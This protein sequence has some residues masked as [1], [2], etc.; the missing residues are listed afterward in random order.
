MDLVG[1]YAR[2]NPQRLPLVAARGLMRLTCGGLWYR[3]ELCLA[4]LGAPRMSARKSLAGPVRCG[5]CVRRD[6]LV[7]AVRCADGALSPDQICRV[8][9]L[10]RAIG[11]GHDPICPP[12]ANWQLRGVTKP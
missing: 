3:A 2:S 11:N 10:A 6:G 9:A 4:E 8:A 1:L 7:G 5:R 12:D